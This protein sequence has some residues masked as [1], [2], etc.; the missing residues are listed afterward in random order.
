MAQGV[1]SR[2]KGLLGTA[3]LEMGKALVLDP[4]NSVHTFFMQYAIDVLFIDKNNLVIEA[5]SYLE[6][7]RMSRIY[8]AARFVIELSAGTIQATATQKGDIILIA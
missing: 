2:I 4:C 5:I 8:P 3:C 1:F 6:P 7:F